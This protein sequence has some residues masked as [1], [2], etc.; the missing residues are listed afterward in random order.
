M[1]TAAGLILLLMGLPTLLAADGDA[2]FLRQW[3]HWRGPMDTGVAPSG[4]PPVQWSE[5]LNVRWKVPLP[6]KGL[7]TPIVW[8]KHLFVTTAIAHGDALAVR[9]EHPEGAH[10]NMDPRHRHRFVVMALDSAQGTVLWQRTVRDQQPHEETHVTGSWS[11]PSPVTDG[12][13]VYASFG[14][15]GVYCLTLD[16]RLV[17]E[18]D[19]GDMQIYHGH[20]EGSSPVLCGDS[21]IVNWDHQGD[22]FVTAL[23]KHTGE[24]RWKVARDE[25]TSWSTPLVVS[26]GDLKQI[27]IAATQ[28]V[29]AYNAANGDLIWQCS[30]LSRNVVASPVAGHGMVYVANSYDW[31]AMLAIR[32]DKAQGDI[33][34]TSAI[35][36]QL[37]RHTPYVPS[38]LLYDKRLYFVRHLQGY[39]S[40]VQAETGMIQFG[41]ERLPGT[42]MLYASP[43]GAAKRVY[44][45]SRNGTTVV[46]EHSDSF[47]IMATNRLADT[48]SASPAIVGKSLYLRGEKHLYCIAE[49]S[50][51]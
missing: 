32:L 36:W 19:L 25:I 31:Q 30:G 18:R 15:Q 46:M 37:R 48:F 12:Q 47:K 1:K 7:S 45:V 34:R 8:G 20:G 38:P 29:R 14:S 23:D 10:D 22:S 16:G 6:G 41:P 13:H 42:Q 43:V 5:D 28:K 27:V 50:K 4:D 35:A 26:H 49:D 44:L 21:L 17:W 51:R 2:D 9:H 40:C 11:S 33:S 3:P 39:V 24:L